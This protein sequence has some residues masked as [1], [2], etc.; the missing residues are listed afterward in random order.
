MLPW[1]CSCTFAG[2][3]VPN[4]RV[5]PPPPRPPLPCMACVLRYCPGDYDD[6]PPRRQLTLFSLGRKLIMTR[7]ISEREFHRVGRGP[8]SRGQSAAHLY[9]YYTLLSGT[10]PKDRAENALHRRKWPAAGG[11]GK[12]KEGFFESARPF[13]REGFHAEYFCPIL[14]ETV[15]CIRA[16]TAF[17]KPSNSPS[18]RPAK[19]STFSISVFCRRSFSLPH[20][21]LS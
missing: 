1:T 15:T 20:R 7:P 18:L 21:A 2:R 16:T 17:V 4:N 3:R 9:V 14:Q 6:P 11:G 12:C 19:E 8:F 5:L 13:S 10:L